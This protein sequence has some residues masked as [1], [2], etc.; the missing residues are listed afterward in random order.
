[1]SAGGGRS[2][3]CGGSRG[4]WATSSVSRWPA[5][6][7]PARSTS[8]DSTAVPGSPIRIDGHKSDDGA[9]QAAAWLANDLET[10]V[11]N[12]SDRSTPLNIAITP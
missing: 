9:Q 4:I 8:C 3:R 12:R 1:M 5:P 10:Q 11:L 2:C 7:G 6:G